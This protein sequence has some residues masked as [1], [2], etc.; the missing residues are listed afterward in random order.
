MPCKRLD[1]QVARREDAELAKLMEEFVCVRIVQGWGLD[2]SIFQFDGDLTWAVVF[3]NADKTIYGRY[4]SRSD[5]KNAEKHI[6][7]EGLKKAVAGA[8]DLHQN[9]SKFK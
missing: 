6:S 8:L 3:L 7:M 9:R 5:Y 1:E 4:G 2:L